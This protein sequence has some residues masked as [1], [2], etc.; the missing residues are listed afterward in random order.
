MAEKYLHIFFDLDRTLWD[1]DSNSTETLNEIFNTYD[2]GRYID[3]PAD[4]ISTYHKINL[5]LWDLYRKGQ[6]TKK[7]LRTERFLRSLEKFGIQDETLAKKIGAE[8]LRV[9]PLKTI[10]LPHT[11]EILEYLH[12]SYRL[13]IITNG[14]LRTQE[15]KMR[16]CRLDQYFTS[17]T[18]SETVGHN[19][20][21]PEIFHHALSSVHARKEQSLM[22]GDDLNV[23][24]AGARNFGMDQVFFNTDDIRHNDPV[25]YE[26]RS[27]LEL[28]VF[29]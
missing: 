7:I 5:G 13:H 21:R 22:I 19:K 2:L 11:H 4:F 10:L 6:M 25:T 16:N 26:I 9:S 1:F 18:T 8:Y 17:M 29:L 3:D 24:I 14:F 28:K 12:P 27:L 20:P 15:I 23:D